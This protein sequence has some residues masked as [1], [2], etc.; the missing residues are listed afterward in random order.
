MQN[1]EVCLFYRTHSIIHV[2]R[3]LSSNVRTVIS[4][5]VIDAAI[6]VIT[7]ATSTS[8]RISVTLY[9]IP[10]TIPACKCIL[11]N[12]WACIIIQK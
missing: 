3:F 10:C 11:S 8:V 5:C 6:R 1:M 9:I 2:S 4:H 12:K 7:M